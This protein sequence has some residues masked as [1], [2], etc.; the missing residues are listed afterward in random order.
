MSTHVINSQTAVT[1]Q[2]RFVLTGK[3]KPYTLAAI[4]ETMPE[5]AAGYARV[6]VQTAGV[7][8]ADVMVRKG[9]VS[10]CAQKSH[11]PWLRHR[12]HD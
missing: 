10:R 6:Q 2:E 9:L 12:R 8:Y 1:T 5:P 7:A 11:D 4:T 3:E